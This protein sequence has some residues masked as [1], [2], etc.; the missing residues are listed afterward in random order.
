[1]FRADIMCNIKG[2]VVGL[3]VG[4]LCNASNGDG[5]ITEFN[6]TRPLGHSRFHHSHLVNIR[7]SVVTNENKYS[8]FKWPNFSMNKPLKSMR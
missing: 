1:M 6:C 3:S 5:G 2:S 8:C 7:S 4:K